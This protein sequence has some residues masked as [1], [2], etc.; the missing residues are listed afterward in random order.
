MLIVHHVSE[1]AVQAH[2]SNVFLLVIV[3]QIVDLIVMNEVIRLTIYEN[4]MA[5]FEI[6]LM[7]M[8]LHLNSDHLHRDRLRSANTN[9]AV[10]TD[11]ILAMNLLEDTSREPLSELDDTMNAY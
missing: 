5:L 6:E 8:E 3:L 7:A 4:R 10:A 2:R 9:V 11:E 1:E